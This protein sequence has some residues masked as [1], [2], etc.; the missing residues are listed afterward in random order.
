VLEECKQ[1]FQSLPQEA[2]ERINLATLPMV[3]VEENAAMVNAVQRHAAV[4]VQKSLAEG[5]GLTVA[6]AMWKARPIVASAIG[7]IQDQVVDGENGALLADPTDLA[8][9][10][11]AVRLLLADPKGAER[12]GRAAR[13]RVRERFLPD[14]QLIEWAGVLTAVDDRPAR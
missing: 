10:G 7:G 14:R 5:F 9:F 6:E 13:E 1:L 11:A 4:V 8:A 2:R 3:D 12:C